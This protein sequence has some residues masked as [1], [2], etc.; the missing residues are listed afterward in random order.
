MPADVRWFLLASIALLQC[1]VAIAVVGPDGPQLRAAQGSLEG[2]RTVGFVSRVRGPPSMSV[3]ARSG[4]T[5]LRFRLPRVEDHRLD[6][7]APP[8]FRFAEEVLHALLGATHCD[9]DRPGL[10]SSAMPMAER[11]RTVPIRRATGLHHG[12]SSY[13]PVL[14]STVRV[15]ISTISLVARSTA[16][17]VVSA[18]SGGTTYGSAASGS[19]V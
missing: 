5:A 3:P 17:C 8:T 11:P 14:G 16:P 13:L 2:P 7:D 6:R 18:P 1:V 15:G 19:T 4:G 10:L 9:E 12:I